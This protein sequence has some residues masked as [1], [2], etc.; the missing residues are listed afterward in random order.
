MEVCPFLSSSNDCVECFEDCPIHEFKDAY[1]NCPFKTLEMY[2]SEIENNYDEVNPD[3][4]GFE[5]L[6]EYYYDVNKSYF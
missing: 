4:R 3:C 1:G 5:F 2:K 6:K